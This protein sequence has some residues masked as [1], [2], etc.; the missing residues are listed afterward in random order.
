VNV[1]SGFALVVV[2]VPSAPALKDSSDQTSIQGDWEVVGCKIDGHKVP[3][4]QVGQLK[5]TVLGDKFQLNPMPNFV[6]TPPK[7]VF[8]TFTPG[9]VE[10]RFLLEGKSGTKSIDLS[11][12]I[13]GETQL[14]QGIYRLDRERMVIC[15]S[16]RDRPKEFL[17]G[18]TD[19]NWLF[20]LRRAKR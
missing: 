5:V 10:Y 7:Q 9:E 17:S 15:Y 11:L 1:I 6:I 13:N 4:E 16:A 18:E 8:F 14:L 3:Q 19:G 12:T 2:L 20:E